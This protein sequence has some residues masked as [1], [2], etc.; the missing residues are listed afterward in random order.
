[1]IL[2]NVYFRPYRPIRPDQ[3]ASSLARS[4]CHLERVSCMPAYLFAAHFICHD[5]TGGR[6]RQVDDGL[7][8]CQLPLEL[9]WYKL[10]V[11]VRG[12]EGWFL[13]VAV[14]AETTTTMAWR[15]QTNL[16]RMRPMVASASSFKSQLFQF[17]RKRIPSLSLSLSF[18]LSLAVSRE[19]T[20]KRPARG[21]LLL[22]TLVVME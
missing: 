5:C 7:N 21:Y 17:V 19:R 1:M 20:G 3:L 18:Y 8:L 4:F 12:R 9:S 22:A 10:I 11:K 6:C 13:V 14:A 15:R 2:I 16:A